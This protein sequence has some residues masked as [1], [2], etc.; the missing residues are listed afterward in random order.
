[1]KGNYMYV[2]SVMNLLLIAQSFFAI[3]H[4]KWKYTVVNPWSIHD[5]FPYTSRSTISPGFYREIDM[6][7]NIPSKYYAFMDYEE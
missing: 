6:A 7:R 3:C 2:H 4:D 5:E 1:M